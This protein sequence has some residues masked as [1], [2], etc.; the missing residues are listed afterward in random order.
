MQGNADW[1]VSFT[2]DEA[3]PPELVV[4]TRTAK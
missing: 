4:T 1:T 3:R 2:P